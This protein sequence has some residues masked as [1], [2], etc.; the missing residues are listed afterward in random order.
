MPANNHASP[1]G[2]LPFLQLNSSCGAV[3]TV[4][5]IPGNKLSKWI[6]SQSEIARNIPT[7]QDYEVY[8][9]LIERE[10]RNSW[11]FTLYLDR[12]NSRAVA[13]HLYINPCSNN[14]FVREVLFKQLQQAAKE[15]LNKAVPFITEE[16]LLSEA[17][18]AFWALSKLLAEENYFSRE[19]KPSFLDASL[20]AYTHPLLDSTLKWRNHRLENKLRQYDNLVCHRQRLL[21]AYYPQ[22]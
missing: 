20:F 12:Q 6:S 3:S 16:E 22:S 8:F 18:R 10:I 14:T 2:V 4:K 5:D 13:Q 7:F 15:E 1:N 11:L 9:S 19:K 21:D 17:G